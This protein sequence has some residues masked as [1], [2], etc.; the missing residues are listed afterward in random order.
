MKNL[1]LTIVLTLATVVGINAQTKQDNTEL[2]A[3]YQFLRTNVETRTPSFTFNRATDSHGFNL[4]A[5]EYV[6]KGAGFTGEVGA[7]FDGNG[8]NL[9]TFQGGIT[10]KVNRQ[11]RVQPFVR[12]LAGAYVAQN[13]TFS[14]RGT[15]TDFAYTLGGGLDV[16]LKRIKWRVVQVDYLGTRNFSQFDNSVRLGTGFVF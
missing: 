5:T 8:R 14:A 6:S 15:R 4:S 9:Y 10:A 11:G 12:A 16:K 7:N 3:G 1:I 2:Y 13:Q